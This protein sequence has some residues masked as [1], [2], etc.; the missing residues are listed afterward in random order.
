MLARR[1][2]TLLIAMV[3]ILPL[4][5]ASAPAEFES[6]SKTGSGEVFVTVLTAGGTTITCEDTEASPGAVSWTNVKG[7]KGPELVVDIEQWGHCTAKTG[8]TEGSAVVKGC[9]FEFQQTGTETTIPGSVASSCIIE[10]FGCTI[11]VAPGPNKELKEVLLG[12]NGANNENLWLESLFSGITTSVGPAC[13]CKGIEAT[14]AATLDTTLILQ[15][16]QAQPKP[17]FSV[18]AVSEKVKNNFFK[19]AGEKGT[20]TIK[21]ITPTKEPLT[22]FSWFLNERPPTSFE[23]N[24]AEEKTCK[25][26]KYEVAT[27][28]ECKFA[29]KLSP[30]AK[31]GFAYQASYGISDNGRATANVTLA[32]RP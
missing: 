7:T 2:S 14:K 12:D 23:P 8:S 5:T 18:E 26:W 3:V 15:G 1:V 31:K 9:D 22:I 4:F 13:G 11:T 27:S 28:L 10:A 29:I 16:V 6:S 25:A 21:N 17:K 20:I 30:G 32:G 19:T 24:Q